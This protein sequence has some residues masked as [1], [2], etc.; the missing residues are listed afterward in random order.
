M[1]RSNH[2]VRLAI[3]A[4]LLFTAPGCVLL[5]TLFG[6][7]LVEGA[8]QMYKNGIGVQD[9]ESS[10]EETWQACLDEIDEHQGKITKKPK[11][12]RVKGTRIELKAGWVEVKPHP[13]MA[14]FT[15]VRARF[16]GADGGSDVSRKWAFTL[17]DGIDARLGGTG[18]PSD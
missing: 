15:R 1:G 11:L 14:G 18:S 5:A 12:D 16:A 13:K 6:I 2:M 9:F 3:L 4:T 8:G 7:G 10:L 17:L